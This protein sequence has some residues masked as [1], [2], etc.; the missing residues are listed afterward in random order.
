MCKLLNWRKEY[1]GVAV[2]LLAWRVVCGPVF[3]AGQ[4]AVP[5]ESALSG[6]DGGWV[7]D[8][9][10]VGQVDAMLARRVVG[11]AVIRSL[12]ECPTDI[13]RAGDMAPLTEWVCL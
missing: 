9:P 11:V 5:I 6:R 2:T 7:G 1:G 10:G 8:D 13:S 12:A 4:G 3:G